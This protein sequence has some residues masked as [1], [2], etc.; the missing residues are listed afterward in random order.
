[1]ANRKERLKIEEKIYN[2]ILEI[3]DKAYCESFDKEITKDIMN[4]IRVFLPS[5]DENTEKDTKIQ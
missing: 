5:K 1:M 3:L 4:V 2:L